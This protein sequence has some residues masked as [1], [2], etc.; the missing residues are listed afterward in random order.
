MSHASPNEQPTSHGVSSPNSADSVPFPTAEVLPAQSSRGLLMS[1]L[2]W[3]T[4]ICFGV[5]IYLTWNA[6]RPPGIPITIEFPDGHGL[7]AGDSLQHRGIEIGIV[8]NVSLTEEHDGVLA[9]VELEK[10]AIGIANEGSQFWIVRPQVSLTNISGLETAVGSKYIAVA[11][12]PSGSPPLRSFTGR[13]TPP[14]VDMDNLGI[15]ILLRGTESFGLT[16]GSPVTYRGI[17]VGQIMS[18]HLADDALT[19][20]IQARIDKQHESLVR[21]GSKFWKTSGVDVD[22]GF[23]GFRLSTDSLAAMARGGVSFSNPK[24]KNQADLQRVKSGHEFELHESLDDDWIK[25]A[26]PLSR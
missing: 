5:A 24:S 2:W 25:Y 16:P 19:V 7:K 22:F 3:I 11:P 9:T 18:A 4:L 1:R 14:T 8:T 17:E 12:G 13:K 21:V 26:E 23:K 6:Q 15:E 20:L 10:T